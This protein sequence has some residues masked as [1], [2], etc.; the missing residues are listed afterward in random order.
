[1]WIEANRGI[2]PI[3][4]RDKPPVR[5]AHLVHH[6]SGIGFDRCLIPF[7]KVV[8]I[9]TG[10]QKVTCPWK[11]ARV[12]IP[13]RRGWSN[14]STS[15]PASIRSGMMAVILPHECMNTLRPCSMGHE[16]KVDVAGLEHLSPFIGM[17]H[18]RFLGAPIFAEHHSIHACMGVL[19]DHVGQQ[20]LHARRGP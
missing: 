10:D 16:A 18:Q 1:M 17:N 3:V 11:R 5:A 2:V 14:C 4:T 7:C 9:S 19:Y 15:I 20:V 12:S 8:W 13:C 6:I